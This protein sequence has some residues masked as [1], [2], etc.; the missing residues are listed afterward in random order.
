MSSENSMASARMGEF[1]LQGS[2][3]QVTM[4]QLLRVNFV[5]CDVTSTKNWEE[6]W[7]EAER[8]LGGKVEIL[9]NNAGVP[10]RVSADHRLGHFKCQISVK[11]I[12]LQAGIE[13]NLNVMSIGATIGV[14]YALERMSVSKGGSGGR[15]ITTASSAGLI[16]RGPPIDDK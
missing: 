3:I 8:I 10:P 13:T 6:A 5:N 14:T 9:C 15:I 16:V 2:K 7:N 11:S 4:N 12:L 1:N